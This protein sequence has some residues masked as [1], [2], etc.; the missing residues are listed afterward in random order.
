MGIRQERLHKENQK[1]TWVA[2]KQSKAKISVKQERVRIYP[3]FLGTW[4]RMANFKEQWLQS[5]LRA[6]H[7]A[8]HSYRPKGTSLP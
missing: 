6:S 1:H 4:L 5:P 2:E 7:S 3:P 8:P